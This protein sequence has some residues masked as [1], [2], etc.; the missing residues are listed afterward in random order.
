MA[1][2]D[3]RG[4]FGVFGGQ[5]VPETL[6][7]ALQEL[8]EKYNELQQDESFKAE[9]G[10]YLKHYIGR[11]TPLYYAKNFSERIGHGNKVYLK[12]ED[13]AHTGAHKMN[14]TIGQAL[15]TLRLGKKRVI[16]ETGA[17]MHGVAAATAASL[18]G[19]ECEVFMGELDVMRQ[20]TNVN[21]MKML[22]A[23]VTPVTSGSRTLKDASNEAMRSW[24]TNVTS[25]HMMIGSVIGP[26]PFPKIVRD[27]QRV[28]GDE[29]RVQIQEA[30]GRLPDMLVAC[31]GGGSNSIG[32][33]YPFIEDKEVD[34]VGV[35]ASG[36]GLN[37]GLHAA[38]ITKGTMGVI[39]GAMTFLLQDED[40]QV[41]EAH[42]VSAGLDYPG[43]GPEHAYLKQSGR[44]RYES[45]TD[46][47]AVDAFHTLCNDEGILPALESSHA[48]AYLLNNPIGENKT[49]VV[50]LSGRGD[51]DMDIITQHKE[52]RS[53]IEK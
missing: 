4:H 28:I 11:P 2:P 24:I 37:T 17:G 22:G 25:S 41:M 21:R 36:K 5:F 34:M 6:F 52:E 7:S 40:G 30:E 8:D 45:A 23:K 29:A 47:Q 18:L 42:S 20:S 27:F 16:A 38:S 10:Y 12:R 35:E 26:H 32:L 3:D 49:V 48:I 13:L 19:L 9:L 31:V 51:K 14:N 44:A 33:F 43:V 15:L 39:H 50:C 46:D 1:L 53:K